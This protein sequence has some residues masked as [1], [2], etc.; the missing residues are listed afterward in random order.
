MMI[1]EP[2]RI[3]LEEVLNSSRLS[4]TPAAGGDIHQ[5]FIVNTDDQQFF[6][7]FNPDPMAIRIFESESRGLE[8]LA[9][10]VLTPKIHGLESLQ[11]QG[12][13]L[14]MDYYPAGT[15]S[16]A[17][18]EQA[19]KDLARLH[20]RTSSLFGCASPSYL[21]TIPLESFQSSQWSETYI[22]GYLY[23]PMKVIREK[24]V[25][26]SKTE[27]IWSRVEDRIPYFIQDDE[28]PVLLHGDLWSG[29]LYCTVDEQPLWIDPSPRYGH[30]EVDLAMTT[31]FG[32]FSSSFYSSYYHHFKELEG[33]SIREKIYQL[34][35]LL[36]H[37]AMFGLAYLDQTIH[38]MQ[39]ILEDSGN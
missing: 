6:V 32:G 21:G 18:W 35:P 28:P 13:Y 39:K 17:F 24:S 1:P 20:T 26:D 12:A 22:K 36:A 15:Y 7:K 38:T 3:R 11:D 9:P 34:Y 10:W 23:P 16:D 2:L 33:W 25:F 4:M 27:E 5:S 14:M 29:N 19:G 30:R 8:E 37:V 31:L